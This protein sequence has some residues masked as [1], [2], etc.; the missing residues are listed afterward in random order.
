[1]AP[2]SQLSWIATELPRSSGLGREVRSDYASTS[3][4]PA[5][6]PGT[7][8]EICAGARTQDVHMGDVAIRGADHVFQMELGRAS[9]AGRQNPRR[10]RT[11]IGS[12]V[13]C[14]NL[15]TS[16]IG[17][18]EVASVGGYTYRMFITVS[19]LSVLD[20]A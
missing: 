11:R 12:R 8:I 16:G 17:R 13:W 10:G 9:T 14:G 5:R 20:L 15:F 2:L 7:L 3:P 1:M 18:R 6:T 4:P 19:P